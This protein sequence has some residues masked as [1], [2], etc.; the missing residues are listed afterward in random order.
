MSSFVGLSNALFDIKAIKVCII[1]LGMG[2]I[3]QYISRHFYSIFL[4]KRR[5]SLSRS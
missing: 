2:I 5:V 4:G 1:F 3:H